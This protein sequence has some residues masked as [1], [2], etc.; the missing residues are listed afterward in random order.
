[1]NATQAF[2]GEPET[3]TYLRVELHDIH[4]LWGG[5][6]CYVWG[7]GRVVAQIADVTQHEDRYTTLVPPG[8]IVKLVMALIE[9]DFVALTIPMPRALVPDEACTGIHLI[10]QAGAQ[11]RVVKCGRQAH[12]GFDTLSQLLRQ[13]AERARRGECLYQGPYDPHFAPAEAP[14]S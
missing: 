7:T 4:P 2:V 14:R 13:L 5:Q 6:A 11:A 12:T 8:E 9:A 10:N 1:M 3:W